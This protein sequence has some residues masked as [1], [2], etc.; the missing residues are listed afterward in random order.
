MRQLV[1]PLHSGGGAGHV[2]ISH[3]L[4]AARSRAAFNAIAS[5]GIVQTMPRRLFL[6]AAIVLCGCGQPRTA[7]RANHAGADAEAERLPF[8]SSTGFLNGLRVE[9]PRRGDITWS[10]MAISNATFAEYVADVAS[11]PQ[12]SGIFVEFEPG[13]SPARADWVRRQI[14]NTGLCAQH[15]CAEVGW[16]VKRPVVN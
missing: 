1:R 16:H 12:G 2:P 13:V 11:R 5:C 6:V 10:G 9:V 15:R 8:D 7:S 4:R 3:V 14:I